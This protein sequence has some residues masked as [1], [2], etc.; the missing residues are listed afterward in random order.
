MLL[1]FQRFIC[2]LFIKATG[3]FVPYV[4]PGS[5]VCVLI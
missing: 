3:D 2:D 4:E 1:E 5:I